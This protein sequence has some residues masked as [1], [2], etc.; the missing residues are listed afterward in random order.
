MKAPNDICAFEAGLMVSRRASLGG[1]SDGKGEVRIGQRAMQLRNF[2]GYRTTVKKLEPDA[3]SFTRTGRCS[4]NVCGH[5]YCM[6]GH[7]RRAN[8][9]LS[10]SL[11]APQ[12]RKGKTTGLSCNLWRYPYC[13]LI[14]AQLLLIVWSLSVPP[15]CCQSAR[16]CRLL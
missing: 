7:G 1:S 13:S 16:L 3:F 6:F 5:G 9:V 12:W 14:N 10:V 8:T 2:S 4:T 11:Y 15:F